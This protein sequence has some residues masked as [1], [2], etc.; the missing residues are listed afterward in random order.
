[1]NEE[2]MNRLVQWVKKYY[3]PAACAFTEL[4]SFGN[5]SDVFSDGYECGISYDAYEIG[6]ILGMDLEEPE[7]A[8]DPEDH[9]W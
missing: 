4:R 2:M 3:D 8:E 5:C 1:M 6:C 7:E 9:D